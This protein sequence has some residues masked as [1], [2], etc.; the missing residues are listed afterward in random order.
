MSSRK[1]LGSTGESHDDSKKS[2]GDENGDHTDDDDAD[3]GIYEVERVID[4]KH[5]HDEKSERITKYRVRWKGFGPIDDTWEPLENFTDLCLPVVQEF[6]Q[7]YQK[8]KAKV[9]ESSSTSHV[10][11]LSE[12]IDQII[13]GRTDV[14][15]KQPAVYYLIRWKGYNLSDNTWEH[16]AEL[17]HA[18]NMIDTYNRRRKKNLAR[19]THKHKAAHID[20]IE[21]YD[22]HRKIKR[23]AKFKE[24]GQ[25]KLKDSSSKIDAYNHQR[26]KS[27]AHKINKRI[28]AAQII[29]ETQQLDHE[30]TIKIEENNAKETKNSKYSNSSK[31]ICLRPG[32]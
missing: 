15:L 28:E 1:K 27:L 30:R 10:N 19:K 26:K 3:Q 14:S 24:N 7:K 29:K 17:K 16:E 2:L 20:E 18:Q 5:I 13:N 31:K 4:I 11:I 21:P 23:E 22:Y 6:R 8:M 12:E 9:A 25:K 32:N